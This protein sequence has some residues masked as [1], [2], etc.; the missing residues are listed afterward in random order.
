MVTNMAGVKRGTGSNRNIFGELNHKVF[1]SSFIKG[2]HKLTNAMK[3][4]T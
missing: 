3:R 4:A 2:I 1:T